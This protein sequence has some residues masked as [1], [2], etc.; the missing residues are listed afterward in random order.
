MSTFNSKANYHPVS[1]L[2]GNVTNGSYML[3]GNGYYSV[4]GAPPRVKFDHQS[5]INDPKYIHS[6]SY[7][8]DPIQSLLSVKNESTLTH[9]Y[10]HDVQQEACRDR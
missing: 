7:R 5:T 10:R 1:Q 6:Q 9:Y 2:A 8:I 3:P 4:T